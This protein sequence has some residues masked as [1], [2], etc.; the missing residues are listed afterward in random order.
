MCLVGNHDLAVLDAIDISTFSPAAAEAAQ[1]TRA[2]LDDG[3]R[4]FLAGLHAADESREVALYHASPRD[5]VWE[6]V[7]WP[8]QA[9]ECIAKQAE[10]VA[11]I[12]HSHIALCFRAADD[13]DTD[14]T[15]GAQV[16]GGT[17]ARHRR[18]PLAAEPRKHRPAARRRPPRR[19][20][21][22]GYGGVDGHLP[23]GRVRG[24]AR[25]RI[26]RGR[27]A[28]RAPR[29]AAVPRGNERCGPPLDSPRCRGSA[30]VRAR[31]LSWPAHRLWPPAAG[32]TRAGRSRRRQATN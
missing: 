14:A 1:W 31:W 10:R 23:P 15:E 25:G 2:K 27:R 16:S 11:L 13:G 24:R 20:A 21:R 5:Q 3:A 12:G 32:T 4:E 9:G 30:Q 6:Y 8:E 7:L 29:Q 17:R 28:P 26:D 18:G 19:L 22:T